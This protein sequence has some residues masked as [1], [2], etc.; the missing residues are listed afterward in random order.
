MLKVKEILRG[1][2]GMVK[3]KLRKSK[4]GPNL[5]EILIIIAVI[6]KLSYPIFKDVI[7]SLGTLVSTWFLTIAGGIFS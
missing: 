2:L 6:L 1:K 7:T 4:G 5:I 3:G